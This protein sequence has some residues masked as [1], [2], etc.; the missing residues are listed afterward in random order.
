MGTLRVLTT[1]SRSGESP[2]FWRLHWRKKL[3]SNRQ[4]IYYIVPDRDRAR[5][6]PVVKTS[7][8]MPYLCRMH[9]YASG[10]AVP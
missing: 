9:K 8:L 10:G 5:A 6:L 3:T 2:W 1:G 7:S 4:I